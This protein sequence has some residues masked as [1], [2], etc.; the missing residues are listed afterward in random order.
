MKREITIKFEG[1]EIIERT[2]SAFGTGCHI[3]VPKEYK[4]KKLKIILDTSENPLKKEKEEIK[5]KS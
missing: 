3:I 5:N 2:A 4:G 1:S